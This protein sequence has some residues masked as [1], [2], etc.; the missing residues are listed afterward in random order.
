MMI[1]I[2]ESQCDIES[3]FDDVL[4]PH[5]GEHYTRFSGTKVLAISGLTTDEV[6]ALVSALTKGIEL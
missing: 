4:N 6:E 3:Q 2:R 1:Q 5:T